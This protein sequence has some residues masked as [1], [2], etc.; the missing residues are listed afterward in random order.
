MATCSYCGRDREDVS[1]Y[2]RPKNGEEHGEP[3]TVELCPL[4][5]ASIPDSA[6][7]TQKEM[8]RVRKLADRR[9]LASSLYR[10]Q[11]II[12]YRKSMGGDNRWHA[13]VVLAGGSR[14]DL[15]ERR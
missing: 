7:V 9:M 2:T 3:V 11:C 12:G 8:L 13:Q 6:Q 15:D 1:A 10:G 5:E 4:C 14:V